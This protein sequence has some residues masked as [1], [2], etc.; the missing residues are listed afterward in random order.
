M[1]PRG[2]GRIIPGVIL[3]VLGLAL[4]AAQFVPGLGG[5][6]VLPALG[7]AF[8]ALYF[9]TRTYGFL[10][11]GCILTGLGVGVLAERTVHLG[12]IEP[13]VLGLGFGF[14]AIAAVDAVY[15][16]FSN[17]WP[18]IPGGILVAVAVAPAFPQ[19]API[20]GKLWP[21][22]LVI[23]GLALVVAALARK[24]ER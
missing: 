20:A 8:L 19:L 15:T 4:L 12:G 3:V 11:P 22:V 17:W 2:D 5:E 21:L 16:R 24:D 14:L 23:V 7:V 9:Y 10:V 1:A 13:V 6:V 18:L